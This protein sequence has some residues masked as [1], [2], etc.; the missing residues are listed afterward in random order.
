MYGLSEHH[1]LSSVTKHQTG[2]KSQGSGEFGF[3][4]VNSMQ[5]LKITLKS[6]PAS[7]CNIFQTSKD[8]YIV[9]YSWLEIPNL[10]IKWVAK[11]CPN[12]AM[13]KISTSQNE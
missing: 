5:R 11:K 2:R 12:V 10:N 1:F 3:R 8:F 9:K 13:Y 4:I 6:F 7:F